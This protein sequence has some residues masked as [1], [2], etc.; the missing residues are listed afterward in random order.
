MADDKQDHQLGGTAIKPKGWDRTGFEAF[1][2]MIYNPDTGEVLTRTPLSWLLIFVFYL[3][4]YCCLAGFWIGCLNIFFLTLPE[5]H[6]GPK[7]KTQYSIIGENPGLGLR[8]HNNDKRIDSQMFVLE[9][10]ADSV[11]PNKKDGEGDTNADYAERLK[12]FLQIYDDDYLTK[13]NLK[14]AAKY[15][16][17]PL[18][19]LGTEVGESGSPTGCGLYPYGYIK[20]ETEGAT[21][22]VAPC[23]FLKLNSIW[24]WNPAPITTPDYT[25]PKMKNEKEEEE[26]LPDKL[27]A[28]MN[29]KEI[30]PDGISSE[31]QVWVDCEGRYPADKEAFDIEYFPKTRG[32][33]VEDLKPTAEEKEKET[34]KKFFPFTGKLKG[35]VYQAPLIAIKVTPKVNGQLIHIQCKAFHQNVIHSTKDKIGMV[36]FEVQ[37]LQ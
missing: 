29:N 5:D 9:K 26:P 7:W 16:K 1:R 35:E 36:Q 33:P 34:V 31:K 19:E 2:Y 22:V 27:I 18:S 4:Y 20:N 23:I 30:F 10:D 15:P 28:N 14:L 37:V 17:F 32:F 13:N 21:T 24:D 3:I 6:D 8:P 12:D 11:I 25:N